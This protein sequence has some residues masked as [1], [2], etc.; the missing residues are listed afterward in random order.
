LPPTQEPIKTTPAHAKRILLVDDEPAIR[1][2]LSIILRRHGFRVTLAASVPEALEEIRRHEFDL[3]L[4]DL[5][6]GRDGDG[7]EVIRAIKEVNPR[8]ITIIQ[9]AF[10]AVES[11]VEGIHL[12]VDD[13]LIKP[14]DTAALVKL[15]EEKLETRHSKARIL[16]VSYDQM[17]LRMRHMILEH[18][19]YAV[20]SAHGFTSAL[21]LCE[22]GGF[23]VF[24]LGHSIPDHEK[25][26]MMQAFRQVCSAPII[27][28]RLGWSDHAVDDAEF[29]IVP[30]PE[31]LL[32]TLKNIVGT[33]AK[34]KP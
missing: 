14:T 27:S 17:L 34:A 29:R 30:D 1:E 26:K 10:P 28:L 33:Q 24:V 11:A 5:N 31:V 4:C 13:Y 7:Y 22:Q 3:L 2:S 32:E 21:E 12:A 25:R 18:E 9:T 8:C 19:G 6:I 16:S 20:V 23:D 15:L